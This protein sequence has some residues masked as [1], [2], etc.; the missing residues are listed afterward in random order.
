MGTKMLNALE[1]VNTHRL[2]QD[3]PCV[4][5]IIRRE[6]I[7]EPA[8]AEEAYKG[9]HNKDVLDPSDGQATAIMRLLRNQVTFRILL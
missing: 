9:L 7:H 6:F 5:E 4:L 2:Q 8:P 3:H 1:Y